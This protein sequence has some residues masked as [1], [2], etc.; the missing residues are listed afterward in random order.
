MLQKGTFKI[1][2]S[3]KL[4]ARYEGPYEVLEI[5]PQIVSLDTRIIKG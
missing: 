4:Q 3:K 5:D 2:T 1:D